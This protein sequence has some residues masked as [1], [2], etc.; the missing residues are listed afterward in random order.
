MESG[1]ELSGENTET[2]I[3]SQEVSSSERQTSPNI[4][5]YC[6]DESDD[7]KGSFVVK[8]DD[9]GWKEDEEWKNE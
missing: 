2:H 1:K 6:N 7:E 5:D 4:I 9:D 8:D 3:Q